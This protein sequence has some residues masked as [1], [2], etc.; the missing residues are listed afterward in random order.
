MIAPSILSNGSSLSSSFATLCTSI[1]AISAS[2]RGSSQRLHDFDRLI[3]QR[4]T[5]LRRGG[6]AER[7]DDLRERVADDRAHVGEAS[8]REAL[9]ADAHLLAVLGH[10]V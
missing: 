6:F 3:E 10:E 5:A 7:V 9:D 2:P 8:A 4:R 1:S